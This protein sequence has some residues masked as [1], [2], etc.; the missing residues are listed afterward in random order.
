MCCILAHSCVKNVSYLYAKN[1][2]DVGIGVLSVQFGLKLD[3]TVLSH[4]GKGR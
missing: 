1:H 3:K 2:R 4:G